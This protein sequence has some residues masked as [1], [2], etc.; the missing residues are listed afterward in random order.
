MR[1]TFVCPQ[2]HF[3]GG[4]RVVAQHAAGLSRLGH[5]VVLVTARVWTPPWSRR[6]KRLLRGDGWW[7]PGPVP[8]F[9][10][11]L[12]VEHRVLP[13]P[14]PPEEGIPDADLVVG[15]WWE[16]ME[17]IGAFPRSKGL[18]VHLVQGYEFFPGQP[19]ERVRAVWRL[20]VQ[21]IAVS[22][23]LARLARDEFGDDTVLVVPN[24]IDMKQFHAAE[25]GKQSRPT[26]GFAYN[27]ST[28]KG[29][30][31]FAPLIAGLR[32][33]IPDLRVVSIGID[34]P[35]RAHPLPSGVEFH[36]QPPQETL[37]DYY[38]SC[39]VWMICSRSEGFALPAL[40]AMACR[41]PVVGTRVG[42]L[43][44]L[45]RDGVNGHLCDVDDLDA[46]VEA[47]VRVIELPDAEWRTFSE[48]AYASV[49]PYE[50]GCA[51][52]KMEKALETALERGR[53]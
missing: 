7:R 27:V 28:V 25:R 48:S 5:D 53:A 47:A 4:M 37:R 22:H 36:R 41:T 14:A 15:T 1:I 19:L 16:T 35:T 26:V 24:G 20:P 17:W 18:P 33:R 3:S 39:D 34:E 38:A 2:V 49:A 32:K 11:D 42:V 45:I 43:P 8:S 30:H 13:F 40:E 23:E 12:Q 9:L 46:L 6:L 31:L 21:R 52:E 29:A 44:E 50:L 51:V 10:D